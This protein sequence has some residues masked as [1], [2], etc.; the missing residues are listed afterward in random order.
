MAAFTIA[1]KLADCLL[2]SSLIYGCVYTAA[3]QTPDLIHKSG[4]HESEHQ[5][6]HDLFLGIARFVSDGLLARRWQL[7]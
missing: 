7:F 4:Q 5:G 6:W 1:M 3:S 2:L